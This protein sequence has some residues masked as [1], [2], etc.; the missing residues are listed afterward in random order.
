MRS[1]EQTS[2][3]ASLDWKLVADKMLRRYVVEAIKGHAVDEEV[4][5]HRHI[6]PI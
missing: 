1:Q 3:N 4:R 5:S 6:D 2:T